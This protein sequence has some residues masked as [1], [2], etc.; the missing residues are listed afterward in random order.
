[1][2]LMK[3]LFIALL[4]PC[5]ANAQNVTIKEG[6]VKMGKTKL[7]SFT[8][9]YEQPKSVVIDAME[10]KITAANLTRDS[11]KKGFS[12]YRSA[13]WPAISSNKADYYY[14]VKHKKGKTMLSFT[15]SKQYN[16]YITSANEPE[17]AAHI[18][19]YL[20]NL[21]FQ[22]ANSEKTKKDGDAKQTAQKNDA[23]AKPPT[24]PANPQHKNLQEAK[25][26]NQQR[27]LPTK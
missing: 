10:S 1:M 24:E 19:Q 14:N 7:W 9:T 5:I 16:D 26:S 22:M 23:L 8:A 21:D 18:K 3:A 13:Q 17:I 11:R 12:I 20:Q 25:P 2:N 4:L 15:V 6:T 27:L